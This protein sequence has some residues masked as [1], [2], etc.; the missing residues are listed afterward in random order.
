MIRR[1]L[2]KIESIYKY[3]YLAQ[4]EDGAYQF[5][6]KNVFKNTDI[7]F[8]EKAFQLDYFRQILV[9]QKIDFSNLRK[10][11]VLAPHQ[12]DEVI[13][14]GG[15]LLR[16]K[17]LNAEVQIIFLTDGK[18]MSN[19]ESSVEIRTKEAKEVGKFLGAKIKNLAI[20]N[21]SL[22][23]ENHHIKQ[24]ETWINEDFDAIFTV[25]PLDNPPKHRLCS[26]LTGKVFENLSLVN[27]PVYLYSVHTDL[28]PNFYED[29]TDLID[30]K[31][32]IIKMYPSQMQVQ[33]YDHLSLGLDAWRTRFL[34]VS[35]E[36]RYIE[37]FCKIPVKSYVDFQ[38]IYKQENVNILFKGHETCIESF[39]RLKKM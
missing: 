2:N 13:G 11:L 6:L 28:M 17:E 3:K 31:Q 30:M 5:I 10:V 38:N 8:I 24:L 34:P 32:K 26:F 12:D 18:E 1:I 35:N 36:I 21:V 19:Q 37:T 39:K 33:R 9:P 25:W 20:D 23:I 4:N 22:Q 27:T 15:V 7:D 14:C 29:I 16:L